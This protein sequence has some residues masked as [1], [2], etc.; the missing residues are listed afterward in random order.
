MSF[1]LVH[2]W[3]GLVAGAVALLL[4]LTG[5]I[6]AIDPVRDAA[7]AV[8]AEPGLPVAT[9]VQ[10][11][12][13]TVPGAEEIRRLPAGDI[14]VYAFD[15]DR[16][17]AALVD[18]ADG[19]V[20][21]EVQPS[22]LSR[23]VKNLHRSFLLGDGGRLAA[24]AVALAMFVVSL[25]GL[26]LLLRR[27]GGWRR[28]AARVHGSVLQRVHVLTGRVVV[29]VLLLTSATALVMSAATFGLLQL[30][31]DADPDLVSQPGAQPD[32]P[33]AALPLLQELRVAQLRKLNFP[34]AADPED[35]WRVVTAQG[36]GWIDRRSGQTLAWQP[37]TLTQ[38]G[39]DWAVLLHT[40]EG[41]W[42]WA[43]VLGL[44][45]GSIP[46]FW[47]SG[48]M[49]WREARRQTPRIARNSALAQAD[50]LIFVASENGST[51]GFAQALHD[52][53]VRNGHAVHTAALEHFAV[54]AAARQVFVLAATYGDGQAPAHAARALERIARQPAGMALV[55]VLGFGDRQFPAFCA[56]A[57]ALD[58][59]LRAKGWAQL[60]PLERIHQQ[61]AQQFALWGQT[62]AQALGEALTPDYAPRVPPTT[63]LRLL[64][65]QD[66][67]GAK[68]EPAVILRL[69]W[70][71][72]SGWARLLGRGWPRF[73]AGDLI[74]IVPRG[75][76]VPRYY[77]LA[78]SRQDG[79]VEICVRRIDGGV[80]ST[81]LHAL[82]PGDAVQAFVRSNPSFALDGVRRRPVVLIGA[83]TGVAPLAGFIRNN[84]RRVPMHLYFGARDPARDFYFGNEIKGW[85]G[86][87]R[88]ASLKTI[89]SRTPG[90]GYVQDALRGDAAQLRDL[91]A[92]GAVLRV[93]GSRPMAKGVAET[94]DA[95]LS[96][97][98][99]SVRQLKTA[100]RYAEDVF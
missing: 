64:S 47:V 95:I 35:T 23:W 26:V 4:G 14:V 91:V 94:L 15:G 60:L 89:F 22:A 32:L 63:A 45:G 83:G 99:L 40:G 98:G 80:C 17:H 29:V 96:A 61:S 42:P 56:Y 41:A 71:Q 28:L 27:L 19:R 49:L 21:G 43:I 90:G 20:L 59:T 65:R 46:V 58:Q 57:E 51:W 50:V 37:S 36:Q 24:A 34:A 88:L 76:A 8:P 54:G 97:L 84:A 62:L 9:L 85:L 74:G 33:P 70:P 44:M 67:P 66:Y 11:V 48:L 93:C 81:Y 10:R 38:R 68:G 39:Y 53:L 5:V 3:L 86:E 55:T 87:G 2:R 16:A 72:Q 7:Q 73:E 30:E 13:A 52:A 92:R 79:F 100:G 12:A 25:S 82:Q 77:S 69:G 1:R 18:P 6:L 78:S 75:S 31:A